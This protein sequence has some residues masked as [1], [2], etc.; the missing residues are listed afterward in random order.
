MSVSSS[1]INQSSP[2]LDS[3]V[4]VKAENVGKIFCRDLKKSLLYGLKDSVKDLVGGSRDFGSSGRQLRKGEFWANRGVSFELRRGE[5]L[6]LIGHNGAGK[7][8]LLKMLNGLIKPDTGTIEMLGQTGAL[9][10]LGAG[11]NQILTGR[12]NVYINGSVLGVTKKEIDAKIDEIIEFAEI[13]EFI[14]S[15]V[16]TYSS[17]M[18]VRLGFA[19]AATIKPDVL[20]IDEVLAVGDSAFKV[21]CYNKIRDLL[22]TTA[23][24]IVSHN[25][26]DISRACSKVMV[27]DHG[28]INYLGNT[29]AGIHQYNELN[30]ET[31]NA[32][33]GLSK[34]VIHRD[35]MITN[36]SNIDYMHETND[37]DTTI[38][39]SF[40]VA[41]EDILKALRIRLV[42]FDETETAV[43]EWDSQ[44]HDQ[45]FEINRGVTRLSLQATN[46]RLMSGNYRVAVVV[47]DLENQGYFMGIER[48]IELAIKNRAMAGAR[49]KV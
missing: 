32:S 27:L 24:I 6:G 25:M 2:D 42:F 47:T 11:F 36:V 16:Q 22:P 7:T 20:I 31:D 48:G 35:N 45:V 14:D 9:I 8:T 10:A 44:Y 33:G 29:Q 41:S 28:R 1:K 34:M 23:V 38:S 13:R 3:E 30:R 18:Q 12:E 40:E 49:Y 46:V 19:V 21:R 26:I 37:L 39:V 5:C 4:L 17:G 15:P 43:A